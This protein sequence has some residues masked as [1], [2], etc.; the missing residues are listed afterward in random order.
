MQ[1]KISAKLVQNL[2]LS[3]QMLQRI[4]LLSLSITDLEQAVLKELEENPVLEEHGDT[5]E[6][7]SS[8]EAEEREAAEWTHY[9]STQASPSSSKAFEKFDLS[10][11]ENLSSHLMWQVNMS[12]FSKEEKEI[13]YALVNELD[14][15]GYFRENLQTLASENDFDFSETE[16]LLKKLQEFDPPGVGAR[17]LK[18]CLLIQAK[19]MEAEDS[20]LHNRNLTSLIEDHLENIQSKNYEQI[21]EDLCLELKDIKELEKSITLLSPD[22]G[23]PFNSQKTEY[24]VP[25]IYIYK[26]ED[27]SY[28]ASLNE[29]RLPQI[30]IAD[31]YIKVL[32]RSDKGAEAKQ[33]LSDKMKRALSFIQ[34]LNHRRKSIL[35]LAQIL[36]DEQTEFFEKGE[37]FLHPLRLREVSQKIGIHLSS[38]S[39][40]T[41]SKYVHTP[42]GVFE[43][44]YFFGMSYLNKDGERKSSSAIMAMIRKIIKDEDSSDMISDSRIA[45]ILFEKEGLRLSRRQ[46]ARLRGEAGFLSATERKKE[47][48]D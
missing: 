22:P 31:H 29:E 41:S 20:S 16:R 40:M 25:D 8:L 47:Q 1:M 38:V 43:L 42:Q 2:K 35:S 14:D 28:Q 17:S 6:D 33:Y 23:N 7:L 4:E 34:A 12:H 39:R 46:V 10:A 30:K 48:K 21:S 36:I 11:S 9:T 3:P 37:D 32:N 13:L 24:V 18:E 27:G 5:L 15:S 19:K 45:Q 44:K 26:K